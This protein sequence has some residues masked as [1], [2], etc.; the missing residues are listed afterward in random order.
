MHLGMHVWGL[1][2]KISTWAIRLLNMALTRLQVPRLACLFG[3]HLGIPWLA[4]GN[5]LTAGDSQLEPTRPIPKA[6]KDRS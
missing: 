3:T 1:S 4:H 2:G 5:V 6:P